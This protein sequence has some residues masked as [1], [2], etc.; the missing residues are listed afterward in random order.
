MIIITTGRNPTQST[1]RLC[2]ELSRILPKSRRLVRGK[3]SLTQIISEMRAD[4]SNRLILIQRRFGCPYRIELSRIENN[5]LRKFPPSII[6]RGVRFPSV[7][8]KP[9]RDKVECITMNSN[10]TLTLG[11]AL[12]EFL[13]IPLVRLDDPKW[14]H[15]LHLSSDQKGQVTIATLNL[16]SKEE[17]GLVIR[18]EGLEW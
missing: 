6:L 5:T 13:Q 8:D 2:K 15:S 3:R 12:S 10:V 1:R 18:V 17:G 7:K 9:F 16:K 11:T 14:S 4:G